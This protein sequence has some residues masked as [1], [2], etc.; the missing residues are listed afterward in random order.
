LEVALLALAN[1]GH[2]EFHPRITS[3]EGAIKT[4]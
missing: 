3:R 1:P 2:F 4:G